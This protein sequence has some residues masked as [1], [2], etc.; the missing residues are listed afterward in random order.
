MRS[1]SAVQADLTVWYAAR[2]RIAGG[3]SATINGQSL[4][5]ADLDSVNTTIAGMEAE[6]ARAQACPDTPAAAGFGCVRLL[7]DG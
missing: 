6:L 3:Q 2:T 5:R 1:A 4:T 7:R